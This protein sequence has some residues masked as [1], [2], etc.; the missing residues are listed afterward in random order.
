MSNNNCVKAPSTSSTQ[1]KRHYLSFQYAVDSHWAATVRSQHER[2]HDALQRS[3]PWFS[4]RITDLWLTDVHFKSLTHLMRAIGDMPDVTHV[5]LEKVTWDRPSDDERHPPLARRARFRVHPRYVMGGCTDDAAIVLFRLLL[6][7]PGSERL[8]HADADRL[9]RIISALS[10]DGEHELL[11]CAEV[12]WEGFDVGV[13]FIFCDKDLYQLFG[14]H[15]TFTPAVEEHT[16]GIETIAFQAGSF[17]PRLSADLLCKEIDDAAGSL[18]ALEILY[19]LSERGGAASKADILYAIQLKDGPVEKW[20]WARAASSSGD[21]GPKCKLIGRQIAGE[22]GWEKVPVVTRTPS[23]RAQSGYCRILAIHLS[24]SSLSPRSH[25]IMKTFAMA[26]RQHKQH[27][28]P[29][30]AFHARVRVSRK[31]KPCSALVFSSASS[32]QFSDPENS[33]HMTTSCAQSSPARLGPASP[34]TMTRRDALD[35]AY[36]KNTHMSSDVIQASQPQ[37]RLSP[38][39]RRKAPLHPSPTAAGNILVYHFIDLRHDILALRST[40]LSLGDQ[41]Y[42]VANI[43]GARNRMEG[44]SFELEIPQEWRFSRISYPG[45]APVWWEDDG[46]PVEGKCEDPMDEE[47]YNEGNAF[48]LVKP[49]IEVLGLPPPMTLRRQRGW[50]Q[51]KR[52]PVPIQEALAGVEERPATGADVP[53]ELFDPVIAWL[54]DESNPDSANSKVRASRQELASMALVCRHWAKLI[55]PIIVE[56]VL[57]YSLEDVNTLR[58]F[59]QNP[60]TAMS[61]YLQKVDI[62]LDLTSPPYKPWVHTVCLSSTFNKHTVFLVARGPLPANQ[63]MKGFHAILPRSGPWFSSRIVYLDLSDV[64]YKSLTHLMRAIGDMPNLEQ[65]VLEKVT[66]D[67]PAEDEAYPPLA[68]RARFRVHPRYEMGGCTDDAAVVWFRFLLQ[69]PGS[70]RIEQHDVDELYRLVT[71][72][73]KNSEHEKVICQKVGYKEINVGAYIGLYDKDYV[74]RFSAHVTFTQNTEGWPGNIKT[75]AFDTEDF[76]QQFPADFPWKDVDDLAAGLPALETFHFVCSGP[77]TEEPDAVFVHKE[78]V[79]KQMPHLHGSSKVR[80][81]LEVGHRYECEWVRASILESE[82]AEPTCKVHGP[83]VVGNNGWTQFL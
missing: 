47:K 37:S 11:A 52:W 35:A 63:V 36:T 82:D 40:E 34:S 33:M 78:V 16:V 71:I 53:E 56:R 49:N 7:C 59:L 17:H 15:V 73:A 18:P 21:D 77:G 28:F 51:R 30:L 69:Y 8:A 31:Q 44:A 12:V 3:G 80:Y 45:R 79:T 38:K 65:V 32:L 76:E 14:V 81:A 24:I 64:R 58:G 2:F 20:E 67:P 26:L 74:W 54:S 72:L 25:L 50:Y 39:Q 19:F 5:Y 66:W 6:Q 41:P 29:G 23:T 4:S 13:L 68:R 27:L 1:L 70:D 61:K 46:T 60:T 83:R 57:L 62:D 75:L 43:C 42:T 48:P 9:Y 22:F 55:Q 10:K